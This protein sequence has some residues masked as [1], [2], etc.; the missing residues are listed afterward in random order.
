[1]FL[2]E[3]LDVFS[4][5]VSEFVLLQLSVEVS[6]VLV[7]VLTFKVTNVVNHNDLWVHLMLATVFYTCHL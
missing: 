3:Y 6:V 5:S 2:L 7:D 1:M 4:R